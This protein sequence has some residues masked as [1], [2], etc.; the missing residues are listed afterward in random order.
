MSTVE[1][2]A[3]PDGEGGFFFFF[4]GFTAA[5]TRVSVVFSEPVLLTQLSPGEAVF[6]QS[7]KSPAVLTD[8]LCLCVHV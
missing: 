4:Y 8:D 2:T 6:F 3:R 7:V 1:R 5:A